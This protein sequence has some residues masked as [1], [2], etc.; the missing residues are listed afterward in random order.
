MSNSQLSANILLDLP[1]IGNFPEG[2]ATTLFSTALLEVL[3]PQEEDPNRLINPISM[4]LFTREFDGVEPLRP[5]P[6]PVI[7]NNMNRVLKSAA[8]AYLSRWYINSDPTLPEY[9]L[10]NQTA[11]VQYEQLALVVSRHFFIGLL[12]LVAVT[13]VTLMVLLKVIGIRK[14]QLFNLQTL[15]KIYTGTSVCTLCTVSVAQLNN[16]FCWQRKYLPRKTEVTFC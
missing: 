13:V 12:A 11:T 5:L 6:L 16:I 9:S 7:N 3:G 4:L 15:E 2:E 8:K 1:L 14:V 10:W